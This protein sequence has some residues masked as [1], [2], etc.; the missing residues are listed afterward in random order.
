MKVCHRLKSANRPTITGDADYGFT[1]SSNNLTG[2]SKLNPYG[3]GITIN[4]NLFNGFQT[5]NRIGQSEASIRGSREQLRNIEQTILQNAAQAYVDVLE[6]REVVVIR[7]KNIG[8]LAEQARSSQARLDVGEGTRT[9]VAQSQARLG[10]GP[11]SLDG[12]AG[13]FDVCGGRDI[14][15][16]SAVARAIFHGRKAHRVCTQDQCK[17]G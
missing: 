1:R 2:N 4:Q 5:S 8:F 6:A 17:A 3:F 13:Q 9:D 10:C 12:G 16:L 14:S 7:R 11:G 15:K